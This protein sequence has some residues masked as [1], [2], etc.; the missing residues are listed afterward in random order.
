MTA[1][2][3]PQDSTDVARAPAP[4]P[5]D[6]ETNEAPPTYPLAPEGQRSMSIDEE[7]EEDMDAVVEGVPTIMEVDANDLGETHGDGV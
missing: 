2:Q 5:M 4:A 6:A 3:A 1:G 7:I